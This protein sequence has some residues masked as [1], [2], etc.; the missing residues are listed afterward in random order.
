VSGIIGIVNLEGAPVDYP[1][2]ARMVESLAL[3]GPD[4]KNTWNE[5]AAGFG[6]TFLKTTDELEHERQPLSLDGKIWVVADARIDDRD[7]L[8]AELQA[9]GQETRRDASDVELIARS[10]GAWQEGCVEH[11]L[12]DFAFAIWDAPRNF[13]FCARDQMGV[14]PFYYAN[15]GPT[16]VFSNALDCI[17][18][19]PSISTRLN[20][21][22]IADFLLFGLNHDQSTTTFNDI[23]RLPPGHTLTWSVLGTQLHRYWTLPI[24]EP[25]F[26]HRGEDYLDEFQVLLQAAVQD[27]VRSTS[28][29]VFMSGGLDS[30]TLAVTAKRLLSGRGESSEVRAFTRAHYGNDQ[31][32]EY[33][34][35]AAQWI[36]IPIE[37]FYWDPKQFNSE[38]HQTS[39]HL[40]EPVPY[41]TDL[42]WLAANY[43]RLTLHSRVALEGEGPDNVL[44]CEWRPYLTYLLRKRLFGRLLYDLYFQTILHRRLPFPKISWNPRTVLSDQKKTDDFPNWFQPSFEKRYELR[45]RNEQERR[46]QPSSHPIHPLGYSSMGAPIWQSIFEQ[47]QPGYTGSAFEVRHPFLDLRMLRFLLAVPVLPWCRH[48]YLL[49]TAMRGALP[50]EVLTRPKTPLMNDPWTKHMEQLG[51]PPV[52]FTPALEEY[53]DKNRVG[54]T[55]GP[56]RFWIDFRVRSLAY[57]LRNV[58]LRQTA[59]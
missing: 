25:V 49:R 57:W 21:R 6:Y 39:Y 48:K 13:L 45:D 51:L 59:P 47:Y 1:L 53:V 40:P 38:W 29:S 36:G 43:R 20:D 9:H 34:V 2:L 32:R 46:L 41:P 27:R 24:D 50:I 55:G 54:Q 31:E 8:L 4:A 11:L 19:H 7:S 42:Q 52:D 56:A 58:S 22:A 16:F 12:G 26:C 28:V 37:L 33:A 23:D 15:L 35:L 17:R 30:T 18:L 5:G 10:Y 3:Y 44:R 14:K